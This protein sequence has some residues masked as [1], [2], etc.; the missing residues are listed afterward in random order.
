MWMA[1]LELPGLD[2]DDDK[3]IMII[4]YFKK[5]EQTTINHKL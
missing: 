3:N 2:D 1:G 4:F 5:F